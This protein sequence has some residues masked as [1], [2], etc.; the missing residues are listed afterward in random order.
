M[1]IKTIAIRFISGMFV[2]T[3][4]RENCIMLF[5]QNENNQKKCVPLLIGMMFSKKTNNATC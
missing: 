4:K 5:V 3:K 1:A 2:G